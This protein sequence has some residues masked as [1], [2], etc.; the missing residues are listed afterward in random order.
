MDKATA[1]VINDLAYEACEKLYMSLNAIANKVLDSEL[2]NLDV[3]VHNIV[4]DIYIEILRPI[5]QQ[6]PCLK[7]QV[8]EETEK[9]ELQ[10]LVDAMIAK[11]MPMSDETLEAIAKYGLTIPNS[12]NVDDQLK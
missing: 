10:K 4:A 7:P 1:K 8:D 3:N 11:G 12:S 6:Y 5:H 9:R 2:E